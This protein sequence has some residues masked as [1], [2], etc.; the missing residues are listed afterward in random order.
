MKECFAQGGMP[1]SGSWVPCIWIA[2]NPEHQHLSLLGF[3]KCIIINS[4]SPW[5]T[6]PHSVLSL[7]AIGFHHFVP[8][9]LV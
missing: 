7:G 4:F 2:A 5:H 3:L 1:F 8:A 6:L 9:L